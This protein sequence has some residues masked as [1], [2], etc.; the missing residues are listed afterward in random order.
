MI[1]SSDNSGGIVVG[2]LV[3]GIVVGSNLVL[4][5]DF[6]S[7]V[8]IFLSSRRIGRAIPARIQYST[9]Q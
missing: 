7:L 2:A 8:D 3:C 6:F 5:L 1:G 4:C 9:L